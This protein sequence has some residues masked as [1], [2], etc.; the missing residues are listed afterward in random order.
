MKRLC[1]IGVDT[2]LVKNKLMVTRQLS[3]CLVS[4]F[5]SM[6]RLKNICSVTKVKTKEFFCTTP[7]WIEELMSF[8][9]RTFSLIYFLFIFNCCSIKLVIQLL[10]ML[11]S[12]WRIYWEG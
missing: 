11:E 4:P 1:Y 10:K 9:L 5:F 7:S 3:V 2:L 12:K 8:S 6:I